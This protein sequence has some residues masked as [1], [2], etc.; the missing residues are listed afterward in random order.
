MSN[1]KQTTA[2]IRRLRQIQ[3]KL[4]R[5][6]EQAYLRNNISDYLVTE[7]RQRRVS[8]IIDKLWQQLDEKSRRSLNQT[9]PTPF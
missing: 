5:K 1:T 8:L 3:L 2:R 6:L 9:Q 7:V 4:G